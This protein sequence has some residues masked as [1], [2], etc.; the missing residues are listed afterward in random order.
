[1]NSRVSSHLSDVLNLFQPSI[2]NSVLSS[3]RQRS[4]QYSIAASYQLGP[5]VT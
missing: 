1:M 4:I 3:Q 5:R 2:F